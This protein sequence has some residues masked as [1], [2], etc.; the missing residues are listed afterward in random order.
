VLDSDGVDPGFE[1]LKGYYLRHSSEHAQTIL[2]GHHDLG[3][4]R[5]ADLDNGINIHLG[6]SHRSTRATWIEIK[7]KFFQTN[8]ENCSS[9][10]TSK[11]ER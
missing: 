2:C 10:E 7:L 3:D 9:C 6:K 1:S 5:I 8:A 11:T 4:E